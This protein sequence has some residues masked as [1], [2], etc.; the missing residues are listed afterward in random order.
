MTLTPDEAA[1][2]EQDVTEAEEGRV[3]TRVHRLRERDRKLRA[4]RCEKT[5]EH[6]KLAC[7]A[8]GFDFEATFGDRG[9]IVDRVPSRQA[10]IGI[11]PGTRTSVDDL[12]L[13]RSNCHRI[14]HVRR[15]WLT[16]G[17]L[18]ELITS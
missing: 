7:E 11:E 2:E 6:G 9:K 18:R 4:A 10:G 5:L 8:C 17:R 12:A 14:I 3:L 1:A 13:V 15:P 16:I